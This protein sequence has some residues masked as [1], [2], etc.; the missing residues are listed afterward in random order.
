MPEKYP[1]IF[2]PLLI[3]YIFENKGAIALFFDN[4]TFINDISSN[5]FNNANNFNNE[6]PG[7]FIRFNR[8]STSLSVRI[9]F[10]IKKTDIKTGF[11]IDIAGKKINNFS[12]LI[13]SYFNKSDR[14]EIYLFFQ[15]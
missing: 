1:V 13:N 2:N 9:Q 6:Y 3:N 14:R 8:F 10:Y 7:I 4:A 5:N 12:D 11:K 15:K